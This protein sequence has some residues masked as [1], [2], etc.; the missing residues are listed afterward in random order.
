MSKRY[1]LNQ[2]AIIAFCGLQIREIGRISVLWR[3]GSAIEGAASRRNCRR[4]PQK[5]PLFFT[6]FILESSKILKNNAVVGVGLTGEPAFTPALA[7][8]VRGFIF[9]L[10]TSERYEYF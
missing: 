2:V 10:L 1:R 4:R 8:Y 5:A 3:G 7:I 6:R 9:M